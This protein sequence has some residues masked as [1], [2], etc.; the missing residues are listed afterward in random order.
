MVAERLG[1]QG[2]HHTGSPSLPVDG[3]GSDR[4]QTEHLETITRAYGLSVLTQESA[5]NAQQPCLGNRSDLCADGQWVP[6]S[7]SAGRRSRTV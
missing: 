2:Q 1:L 4:S 6:V 5:G 7:Q 3:S